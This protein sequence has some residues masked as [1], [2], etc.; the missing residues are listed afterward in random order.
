MADRW[1]GYDVPVTTWAIG[2]VHGCFETLVRLL[3]RIAFDPGRDRLWLVGDLVNRGPRSLE[4]LRWAAG[5]GGR[6]TAVMG[7][8]DLHLLLRSRGLVGVKP[9]DRLDEVLGAPD[10][11]ELLEWLRRRPFLH[12][13]GGRVLVHAGLLPAWGL[14]EAEALAAELAGRLGGD[15]GWDA[16]GDLARGAHR[17]RPD[18]EGRDRLSAAARILT[19]LR[20]VRPDGSPQLGYTGRPEAAP[21]GGRP[22]F[23]LSPVPGGELTVLFGHWAQLG[24]HRPPGVVCLD[25]ACVYGGVLSALDLEGGALVQEPFSDPADEGGRG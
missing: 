10:R 3:R 5:L 24:L 12:R 20:T 11:D 17:W 15:G 4:V 9:G 22:W 16:L 14:D 19:R 8:H 21:D 2:D 6:V 25:S 7:N 13:E 1:S 23:E 18:L